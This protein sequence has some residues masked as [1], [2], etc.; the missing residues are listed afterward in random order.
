MKVMV[1]GASGFIGKNLIAYLHP[2][3][4]IEVIAISRDHALSDIKEA[5]ASVDFLIHLAGV[6]RPKDAEEYD[7]VNA[8]L[9]KSLANA[10]RDCGRRIPV[11]YASST[12]AE[13]DNAY[14]KSK[15]FAEDTLFRLRDE[16]GS[17]VYVFRLP[18][19][20]GKWARPNYN[21]AIATFCH[22]VIHGI[23][24][25]VNDRRTMLT[26]AYI[27][28]VMQAFLRIIDT[29]GEPDGYKY[30]EPAYKATLGEIVALLE[31]FKLSRES[32][33]LDGVGAGF[34]RALYATFISYLAP[35]EFC[36]SVKRHDDI[37][38]EF[39]EFLKTSDS[40]QLSYFTVK[41][42]AHRGGHYHH[43]KT[44]KFLVL[45]GNAE[46]TFKHICTGE[47]YGL[48]SQGGLG[49]VVE[50]IPGWVH[51]IANVGNE[52]MIVLLWANE[53][54]NPEKPD[55]ITYRARA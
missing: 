46:F 35:Q 27:D 55:T 21:S 41:P 13:C 49:Q 6:N 28:D 20:F 14:G 45:K 16:I 29:P 5:L 15:R 18:N 43:T 2:R 3:K 42:G 44:E 26:L 51:D 33:V 38:G 48:T 37:R 47:A 12:Q 36:Y 4:D 10:I 9:T 25:E 54:F 24:V 23:P 34:R 50:T 39:V 8:G 52:E 53:I 7:Q 1:T 40:G 31:R 30:V 19:V 11:I 17:R 22:N 32:L